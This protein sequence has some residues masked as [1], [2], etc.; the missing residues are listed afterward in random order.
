MKN[1]TIGV[2]IAIVA[3]FILINLDPV[4]SLVTGLLTIMGYI[5]AIGINME[6]FL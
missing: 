3:L 4:I 2:G 6:T 5:I 1:V